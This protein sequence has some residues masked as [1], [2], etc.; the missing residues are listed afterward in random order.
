MVL[1]K[2][3]NCGLKEPDFWFYDVIMM[4]FLYTLFINYANNAAILY[5]TVPEVCILKYTF[6][7]VR[8]YREYKDRNVGML[9]LSEV[10]FSVTKFNKSI[11]ND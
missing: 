6:I 4:S 2:H 1:G 5:Q 9:P 7:S 3:R 8:W 11:D 10:D